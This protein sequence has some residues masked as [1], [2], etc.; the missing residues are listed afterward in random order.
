MQ[1]QIRL[2]LKEQSDQGLH[3]LSFC[4]QALVAL[5]HSTSKMFHFW[6][7]TVIFLGVPIFTKF[8]VLFLHIVF[9]PN[10]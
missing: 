5:L 6:V 3:C 7:V 4:Q 9:C 1:A 8:I 2:I 10:F